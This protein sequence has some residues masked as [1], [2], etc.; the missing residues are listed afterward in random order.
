MTPLDFKLDVSV[1]GDFFWHPERPIHLQR[2]T[3]LTVSVF[4]SRL[5]VA[6]VQRVKRYGGKIGR[7]RAGEGTDQVNVEGGLRLKSL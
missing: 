1:G 2:K 4:L 7:L 3:R 6:S 5:G